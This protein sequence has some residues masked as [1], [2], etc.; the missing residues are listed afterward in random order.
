MK[1]ALECRTDM[2]EMVQPF[3]DL[4]FILAHKALEDEAYLAFYKDSDNPVKI[5]DNS[6]NELGEPMSI[7]DLI[8]AFEE[9]GAGFLV[10]PDYIGDAEKKHNNR[11]DKIIL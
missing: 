10:A 3:S 7:D 11:R 8:R 2:L 6:V 9:V 5:L 4:D 1:L